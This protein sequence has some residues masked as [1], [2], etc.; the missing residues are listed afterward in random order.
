[1]AQNTGWYMKLYDH[2]WDSISRKWLIWLLDVA[3]NMGL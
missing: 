3:G 2:I 1:M